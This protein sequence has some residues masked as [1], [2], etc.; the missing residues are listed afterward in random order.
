MPIPSLYRA[1]SDFLAWF[2][3][4][5]ICWSSIE[6][7]RTVLTFPRDSSATAIALAEKKQEMNCDANRT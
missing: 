1:R 2:V 3:N 4:V 7:A 6:N 5:S